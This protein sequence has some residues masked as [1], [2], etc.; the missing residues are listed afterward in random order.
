MLGKLWVLVM[1][2]VGLRALAGAEI[3]PGMTLD[4]TTAEEAKD[5][6]PPEIL[7]HFQNGDYRNPVVDF[8]TSKFRWDDG[9]EEATKRNAENLVLDETKQP[10]DKT[11]R[12]RP[13]YITG[14]PFP[15]VEENDP[16]GGY[17]VLWNLA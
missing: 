13:D 8:P 17:K 3:K 10:V 15:N 16:D 2:L 1:L 7:K 6:L 12:Q 14:L 11:T 5:L 4:K 9:F